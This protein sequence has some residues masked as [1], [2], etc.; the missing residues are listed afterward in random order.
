MKAAEFMTGEGC[1]ELY[2]P[3]GR[4]L[5]VCLPKKVTWA[6]LC[7]DLCCQHTYPSLNGGKKGSQGEMEGVKIDLM[8]DRRA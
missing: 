2:K 5:W 8:L 3:T 7:Y 4:L 1:G 6:S